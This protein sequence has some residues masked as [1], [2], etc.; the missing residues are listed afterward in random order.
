VAE[1]LDVLFKLFYTIERS[2]KLHEHQYYFFVNEDCYWNCFDFI[3]VCVAL[4]DK[5]L[6][7]SMGGDGASG[8]NLTF[9]RALRILRM[10][11]ILRVFRI[12]R[13]LTEL[14]LI[15]NS[16]LGSMVSLF[17]SIVMM[18]LIFYMFGLVFVQSTAMY[19]LDNSDAVGQIDAL[20]SDFG[21]VQTSMLSLYKATTGGDDWTNYYTEL[22]PLG[23]EVSLLF[24]FFIAF[25][26]IAL[27]NILTG[28][29]VENAIKLAQPDR[30]A[31]FSEQQKSHWRNIKELEQIMR[32]TDVD[33]NGCISESEFKMQMKHQK[34][35][36][37]TYLGASG[38]HEADAVR[39]FKMLKAA[40]IDGEV[41]ITGFIRG[42][43]KLTGGAQSL[44]IQAL[45]FEVNS[46]HKKV[47]HLTVKIGRMFHQTADIHSKTHESHHKIHQMHQRVHEYSHSPHTSGD[48]GWLI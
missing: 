26:Q 6:Q 44:D 34:S 5:F 14:R 41:D 2:T 4:F 40:S 39:F 13:F 36:L 11:K 25:S 3:L 46:L 8:R 7:L 10:A 29:F 38:V 22:K 24:L 27:M 19:K 1:F 48:E 33:G 43:L 45:A 32:D 42:L 17:W 15:L 23:W 9:L 31:V 12:M 28:L 20:V 18:A 47:H 37:R 35:K 16:L 30:E 21:D